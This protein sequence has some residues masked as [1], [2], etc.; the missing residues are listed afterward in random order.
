MRRANWALALLLT[1]AWPVSGQAEDAFSWT[2]TYEGTVVCDD[3]TDGLPS[4]FKLE[5]TF[6]I[7]QTDDRID[8]STGSLVS[9][10]AG[11]SKALYR[12]HVRTA[13]G[14]DI[15]SG[16]AEVCRASF[17]YRELARFFPAYTG[18]KDFRVSADTIFVSDAVPGVEGKL[19]TESCMWSLKRVST[20]PPTI[21]FCAN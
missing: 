6:D 3:V 19:V 12:G 13:P 18:G 2:G 9:A 20:E 15:V 8:I 5:M 4:T 7:V 17:P 1:I 11:I 10:E 21:E 14:G 16:Y